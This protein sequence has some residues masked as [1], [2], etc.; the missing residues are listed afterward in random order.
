MCVNMNGIKKFSNLEKILLGIVTA[1]GGLMLF[2]PVQYLILAIIGII[3]FIYLLLNP[4]VCFYFFIAAST[5]VYGLPVNNQVPFDHA[6]I[7]ITICFIS[8]FLRFM[9]VDK[10]KVN[11]RTKLDNWLILLLILYFFA[12][13]TSLSHRGYQG[14]LR[15]GE[16]IAVFY[17]TVYF[18]RTKVITI[19]KLIK[20]ILVVGLL[21]A[22]IGIF[23]SITGIG[24]DFRDNRG[25]LGYLGL[26]SSLV[27]HGIGTMKHFN[28]LGA[29]L[30]SILLF[31]IP[32]Y[33]FII[34]NKKKGKIIL[35]I[36]MAGIITTY[37][38]NALICVTFGTL[39]FYYFKTQ[40]KVKFS[41]ILS[42]VS[43]F[44]VAAYNFLKNTSY[45]AT[46]SPRND[47]WDYCWDVIT[48][49]THNFLLGTGLKSF[50]EAISI[51]MSNAFVYSHAHNLYISM[52]LETG[53]IGL[54][55]IL[56]FLTINIL[57]AYKNINIKNKFLKV[58]NYSIFLY[59]I[60][61]LLLGFFDNTF[62]YFYTQIWLYLILGILYSKYS[63]KE[64]R[65]I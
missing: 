25:Y 43:T 19:S 41:F 13:M 10:F 45:L 49:S 46:L 54:M 2:I 52:F 26:G 20:F 5:W 60:S 9:F 58:L 7:L 64:K 44:I 59:L 40:N 56:T 22:S 30:S 57:Y 55:L 8:T 48:S 53:I 27:W 42:I 32:I 15:F 29:F 6:D 62:E 38:R 37:S 61:I 1:I 65:L 11:M 12:G 51:Y 39:F 36:L 18:I 4:K 28:C 17:M 63:L 31:F 21:Q 23:Q 14:F 35:F 50:E 33:H 34:K 16:A 47:V 24:S 3:F